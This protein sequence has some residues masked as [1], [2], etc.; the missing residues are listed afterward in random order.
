MIFFSYFKDA[1]IYKKGPVSD[2]I[3]EGVT[4]I[5]RTGAEIYTA[6]VVARSTGR[7]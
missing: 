6:V 5:V 3:H 7:W 1:R 4:K 2:Q